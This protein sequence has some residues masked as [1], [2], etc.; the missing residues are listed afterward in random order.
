M[1]RKKPRHFAAPDLIVKLT[2]ETEVLKRKPKLSV[3][4]LANQFDM[5][6]I[7]EFLPILLAIL[8][9]VLSALS[10][11]KKKPIGPKKEIENKEQSPTRKSTKPLTFEELLREISGEGKI[12]PT[13]Y[14]EEK[15][16]APRRIAE[17]TQT[18]F[19]KP[20][21][22]RFSDFEGAMT[23]Q[24]RASFRTSKTEEQ[25][26]KRLEVEELEEE[27]APAAWQA[28]DIK[29]MLQSTEGARKAII[30]SEIMRPKYF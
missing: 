11:K 8:Y 20:E 9:F 3:L 24:R 4:N 10:G 23:D 13:D 30:L 16:E 7:R 2:L 14:E 28:S 22:N 27:K 21:K 1:A 18:T 19:S 29:K 26:K 25:K 17:P 12:E 15:R 6:N 5:E